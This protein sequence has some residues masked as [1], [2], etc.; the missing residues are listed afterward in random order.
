MLLGIKTQGFSK[1][2]VDNREEVEL[3]NNFYDPFRFKNP[4]D[5]W[6]STDAS[7]YIFVLDRD[8]DSLYQFTRKGYEGVNP[9]ANSHFKKNII[10]SFGGKGDGPY[11]FNDPE[12]VCYF[13]KIVYVADKGNNRIMRYKLSTDIE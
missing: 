11:Q 5:V 8:L 6:I 7:G 12:G 9:P 13:N 2:V 1:Y 3:L 10:V 4:S